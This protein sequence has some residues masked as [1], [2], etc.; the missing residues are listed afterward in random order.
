MPAVIKPTVIVETSGFHNQRIAVPFADGIT[1]PCGCHL[2]GKISAVGKNLPKAVLVFVENRDDA[3]SLN[4]FEWSSGHHHRV[5]Y[6]VGQ[7]AF[8][9]PSF[10]ETLLSLFVYGGYPRPDGHLNA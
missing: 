6:S 10:R 1:D 2:F 4:N 3:S 5:R 7:T 8:R 9:W